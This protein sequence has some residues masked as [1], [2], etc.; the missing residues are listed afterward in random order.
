MELAGLPLDEQNE[1]LS[2]S[3]RRSVEHGPRGSAS[4]RLKYSGPDWLTTP[5]V[6]ALER[7]HDDFYDLDPLTS[8]PMPIPS[9]LMRR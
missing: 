3:S 9:G 5:G 6:C 2:D 4:L 8:S 1:L 7:N